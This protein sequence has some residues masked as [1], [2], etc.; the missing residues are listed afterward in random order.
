MKNRPG[1]NS[2][3]CK[4]SRRRINIMIISYIACQLLSECSH[5]QAFIGYIDNFAWIAFK[6]STNGKI[7]NRPTF[8]VIQFL[9]A[10]E[11]LSKY[12]YKKREGVNSR[13]CPSAVSSICFCPIVLSQ[14]G[15]N[16][17]GGKTNPFTLS[18]RMLRS[19]FVLTCIRFEEVS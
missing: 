18:G 13:R 8:I 15:T 11:L 17:C 10:I 1:F 19:S 9:L 3:R 7:R 5:K 2:F 4:R 14:T 12:I 16:Q 6:T